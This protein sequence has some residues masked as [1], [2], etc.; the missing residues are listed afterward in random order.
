M[1]SR[2]FTQTLNPG[3]S[4]G[5]T[6]AALKTDSTTFKSK[7]KTKARGRDAHAT[8]TKPG[9]TYQPA[10]GGRAF[11]RYHTDSETP[12]FHR[13]NLCCAEDRSTTFESK[14]KTKARGR[15]AH[16][17]KTRPGRDLRTMQLIRN[18]RTLGAD[19]NHFLFDS[20]VLFQ[21]RCGGELSCAACQVS[22]EHGEFVGSLRERQEDLSAFDG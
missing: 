2:V 21:M 14:T 11:S 22:A 6:C 13:S 7:T 9:P 17:T 18:S 3:A 4:T 15:D 20:Y 12:R 19:A 16:A 1:Y 10:F 5:T 8:K